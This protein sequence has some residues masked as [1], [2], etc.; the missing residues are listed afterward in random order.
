MSDM[1]EV[2]RLEESEQKALN[3]FRA[4][5]TELVANIGQLEVQKARLLGQLG[6]LENLS[7]EVAQKVLTRLGVPTG[8][9]FNMTTEGQVF[10][11]ESGQGE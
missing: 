5:A 1:K 7:Q 6:E 10:V 3:A 9:P 4:R 2:G 11:P 8:T